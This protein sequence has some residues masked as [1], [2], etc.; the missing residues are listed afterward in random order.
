MFA[1]VEIYSVA[2]LKKE[3]NIDPEYL[4]YAPLIARGDYKGIVLLLH[5]ETGTTDGTVSI[6]AALGW[7]GANSRLTKLQTASQDTQKEIPGFGNV[8]SLAQI[9]LLAVTPVRVDGFDLFDPQIIGLFDVLVVA[10]VFSSDDKNEFWALGQLPY[11]RA[12][13]LWGIGI[14]VPIADIEEALKQIP[15]GYFI[16]SQNRADDTIVE[17]YYVQEYDYRVLQNN[18]ERYEFMLQ[19]LPEGNFRNRTT[20]LLAETNVRLS[21]VGPIIT[22]TKAQLPSQERIDA[23]LIRIE[24]R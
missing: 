10:G 19:T 12:E 5:T 18:K 2:N 13:Q 3:L 9:S 22:A 7:L 16:L 17:Y 15:E 4:N 1:P 20:E 11:T 21:E 14:D 24:A 8:S 23:A 6:P